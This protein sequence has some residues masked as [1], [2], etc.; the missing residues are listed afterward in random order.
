MYRHESGYR[1]ALL[2]IEY[3]VH[4]ESHGRVTYNPSDQVD[5]QGLVLDGEI[6]WEDVH[7]DNDGNMF[8]REGMVVM[9]IGTKGGLHEVYLR[10][11]VVRTSELIEVVGDELS[12][13][14]RKSLSNYSFLLMWEPV[15]S[16]SR[17]VVELL[18]RGNRLC[19]NH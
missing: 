14:T 1:S 6:V 9:M 13:V 16:I 18:E 11:T 10:L 4:L 19:F 15:V 8:G 12:K 17:G 5:F 7:G 2:G 3:A